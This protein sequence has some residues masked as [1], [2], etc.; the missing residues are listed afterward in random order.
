MEVSALEKYGISFYSGET[1]G[2]KFNSCRF[3]NLNYASLSFVSYLGRTDC[4]GLIGD[5]Q[6]SV[7][8][9]GNADDHFSSD[10]IEDRVIAYQYPDVVIDDVLTI[11]MTDLLQ[12]VQAWKA[13]IG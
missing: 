4:N 5:L 2:Y 12:I 6:W 3:S 7:N 1:N 10:S 9:G 11:S 13:F 8:S